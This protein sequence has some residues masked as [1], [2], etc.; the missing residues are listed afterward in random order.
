MYATLI[1]KAISTAVNG[2]LKLSGMVTGLL[3]KWTKTVWYFTPEMIK[4]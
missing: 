1:R 2:F 3:Q 4:T